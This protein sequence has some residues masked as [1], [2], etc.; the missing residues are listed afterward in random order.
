M[1]TSD[2]SSVSAPTTTTTFA[3]EASSAPVITC[4][5]CSATLAPEV[6]H[7]HYCDWVR[8]PKVLTGSYRDAIAAGLSV[9]PGLGHLF[10]GHIGFGALILFLLGPLMLGLAFVFM[11]PTMGLSFLIL[12]LFAVVVALHAFF[13]ADV[14]PARQIKA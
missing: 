9:I 3:P 2:A 7:C 6:P 10:K 8:N 4:P 13:V 5:W 12:P 11:A 1:T 14:R